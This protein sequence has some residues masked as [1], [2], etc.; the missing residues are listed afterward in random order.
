MLGYNITGH[1]GEFSCQRTVIK[2]MIYLHNKNKCVT[3][4]KI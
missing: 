2:N 4:A 1:N 3:F